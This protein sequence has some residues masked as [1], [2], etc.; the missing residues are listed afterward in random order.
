M[1]GPGSLS[2]LVIWGIGAAVGFVAFFLLKTLVFSKKGGDW[3]PGQQYEIRPPSGE[4]LAVRREKYIDPLT[5]LNKLYLGL[6]VAGIIAVVFIFYF[7]TKGA[8]RMGN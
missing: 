4:Q 8:L 5:N 7:L 1:A 2:E 6:S 3:L